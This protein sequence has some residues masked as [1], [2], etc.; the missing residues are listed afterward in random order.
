MTR[1]IRQ[2]LNAPAPFPQE[3]DLCFAQPSAAVILCEKKKR[4][5]A[6]KT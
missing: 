3:N 6:F 5:F 2:V 1:S 4:F